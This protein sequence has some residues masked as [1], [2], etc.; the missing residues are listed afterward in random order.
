MPSLSQFS[1]KEKAQLHHLFVTILLDP[2]FFF[3]EKHAADK[4]THEF[5]ALIKYTYRLLFYLLWNLLSE[6]SLRVPLHK[7][8]YLFVSFLLNN[9]LAI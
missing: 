6:P 4:S 9:E 5:T 8:L 1:N 7:R 3:N 2:A